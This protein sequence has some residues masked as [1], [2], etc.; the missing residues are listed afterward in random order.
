MFEPSRPANLGLLVPFPTDMFWFVLPFHTRHWC[1]WQHSPSQIGGP[2]FIVTATLFVL[3]ACAQPYSTLPIPGLISF[4]RFARLAALL[5]MTLPYPPALPKT[6]W[7]CSGEDLLFPICLFVPSPTFMSP[8]CIV[9][10]APDPYSLLQV[11][12]VVP[13]PLWEMEEGNGLTSPTPFGWEEE[14]LGPVFG[15]HCAFPNRA[16]APIYS[17]VVTG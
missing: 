10:C 9:V 4:P 6:W 2:H 15:G 13:L 1:C 8:V 14:A 11:P 16:A 3:P 7:W 17:A 12:S 5:C